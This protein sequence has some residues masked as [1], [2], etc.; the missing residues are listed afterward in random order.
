[1]VYAAISVSQHPVPL[2]YRITFNWIEPFFATAGALQAYIFPQSLLEIEMPSIEYSPIL[3]PL[4]TQRTGLW[5][6]LALNDAVTLRATH[7]VIIW[8]LILAGGL[9]SGFFY[10]LNILEDHGSARFWNPKAW[11]LNDWITLVLTLV[12]MAIKLAYVAG[13]GFGKSLKS[14]KQ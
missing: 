7:D 2:M 10:Y 5:L 13:I 12:P 14:K 9:F 4:F 8:R 6:L 11:D 3:Q 1:M